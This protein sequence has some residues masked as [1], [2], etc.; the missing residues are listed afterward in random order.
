MEFVRWDY[1]FELQVI[2]I[3]VDDSFFQKMRPDNIH[4]DNII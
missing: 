1:F 2:N 4:F 3:L